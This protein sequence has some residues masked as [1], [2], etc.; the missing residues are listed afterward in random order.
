MTW[1]GRLIEAEDDF[2]RMASRAP[3]PAP[4][5]IEPAGHQS[6]ERV[7]AG[8]RR[9]RVAQRFQKYRR[10]MLAIDGDRTTAPAR[11]PNAPAG[12]D[13]SQDMIGPLARPLDI[14]NEPFAA[15]I[16]MQIA[17]RA[18]ALIDAPFL[19]LVSEAAL[20]VAFAVG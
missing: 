13:L 4:Q 15:L 5:P 17:H 14:G 8:D 12:C 1:S 3:R 18:L 19:G 20:D 9:R 11:Q 2:F 16:G 7:A 6:A 10:D